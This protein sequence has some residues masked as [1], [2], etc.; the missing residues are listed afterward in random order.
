MDDEHIPRATEYLL[1]RRG[2]DGGF[3]AHPEI[4]ASD[5]LSTF[6]AMLSLAMLDRASPVC[7][8]AAARFARACSRSPGGFAAAPLPALSPDVEYTYYGVGLTG[9][10][11]ASLG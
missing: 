5:L 4:G 8:A 3:A 7:L 1:A 9:L 11:R 6:T 2:A 10:L